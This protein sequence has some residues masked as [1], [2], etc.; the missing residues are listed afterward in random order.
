M[1]NNKDVFMFEFVYGLGT[2][3]GQCRP[4]ALEAVRKFQLMIA[5]RLGQLTANVNVVLHVSDV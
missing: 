4:T 3:L 2:R 1:L 5:C